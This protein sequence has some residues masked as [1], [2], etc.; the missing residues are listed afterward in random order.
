MPLLVKGLVSIF[1][2]SG[3]R[4]AYFIGFRMLEHP[5]YGTGLGIV[6]PSKYSFADMDDHCKSNFVLELNI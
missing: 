4:F 1:Y 6:S 2:Y 5:M 3:N